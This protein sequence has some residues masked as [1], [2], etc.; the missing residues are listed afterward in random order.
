MGVAEDRLLKMA[1]KF[2]PRCGAR[3]I[4]KPK[5]LKHRG[6]GALLEVEPCKM[7]TTLWRERF[8]RKQGTTLWRESGFHE[9]RLHAAC[10]EHFWKLSSAKFVPR[11]GARAM[12]KSKPLKYQV[13]G[14]FL[15]VQTAFCVAGAGISTR[16][17]IRGRRRSS[18]GLQQHWQAWWI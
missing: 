17:K 1:T 3:A 2:A 16:C 15:E 11:C 4:W 12:W 10:S 8:P 14:T 9:K 18:G 6:F 5:S 7:C 13:L